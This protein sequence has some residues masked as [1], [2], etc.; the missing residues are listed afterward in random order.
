MRAHRHG[1]DQPHHGV[2]VLGVSA[3]LCAH[4]GHFAVGIPAQ[5]AADAGGIRSAAHGHARAG[6]GGQVRVRLGGRVCGGVQAAARRDAAG[7]AAARGAAQVLR[8]DEV[9]VCDRGGGGDGLQR[10][11]PR[12]VFRAGR[13]QGDAAARGRVGHREGGRH[14]GAAAGTDG[15]AL[16]AGAVLRVP[17]GRQQRLHVRRGVRGRGGLGLRPVHLPGDDVPY[18]HGKGDDQ[19]RGALED[20]AAHLRRI[21]AAE[22]VP[23]AGPAHDRAVCGVGRGKGRHAG[24]DQHPGGKNEE[25]RA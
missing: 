10:G 16:R 25:G 5:A 7:G 15:Q 2:A 20:L 1:G 19:R 4:H 3:Q 23:A 14:A 22:R 21:F 18:V 17:G 9:H 11:E 8:A 13:A 12:G 24:G 6:C